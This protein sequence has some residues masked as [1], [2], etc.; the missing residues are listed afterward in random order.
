[1]PFYT[2]L[3]WLEKREVGHKR[4]LRKSA[5]EFWIDLLVS[6]ITFDLKLNIA[7]SF[8]SSEFASDLIIE[9][10]FCIN[11]TTA[12]IILLLYCLILQQ[13]YKFSELLVLFEY[14]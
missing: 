9:C 5:E 4:T 1:M 3:K 8:C 2:V 14:Q 11:N 7:N 12:L 13:I 6:C 10:T